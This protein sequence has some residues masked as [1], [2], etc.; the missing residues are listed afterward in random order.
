[1]FLFPIRTFSKICD[2]CSFLE[3]E[4]LIYLFETNCQHHKFSNREPYGF[5]NK[6][7]LIALKDKVQIR[8]E[9]IIKSQNI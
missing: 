4:T 5:M 6:K 8:E 1:M 2:F 7:D 9:N 3:V